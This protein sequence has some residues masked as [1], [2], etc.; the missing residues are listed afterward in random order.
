MSG[1]LSILR[2]HDMK[3]FSISLSGRELYD[4]TQHLQHAAIAESNY[5]NLA[6]CV[7]LNRKITDQAR[8]Q[9][10]GLPNAR[11]NDYERAAEV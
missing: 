10:F 8:A 2:E 5:D 11:A 6:M 7:F 1:K 3:N 4:L 9:G